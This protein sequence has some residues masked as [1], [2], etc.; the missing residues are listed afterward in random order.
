MNSASISL[1]VDP[2]HHSPSLPPFLRPIELTRKIPF[3]HLPSALIPDFSRVARDKNKSARAPSSAN[4]YY[5]CSR[6]GKRNPLRMCITVNWKQLKWN[7]INACAQVLAREWRTCKRTTLGTQICCTWYQFASIAYIN[8]HSCDMHGKFSSF[9]SSIP[10]TN[11]N[12]KSSTMLMSCV[13]VKTA[14]LCPA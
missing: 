6:M 1:T 9:D 11:S 12:A 10:F 14:N 5:G 4:Y 13:Q 3:T 8:A 7:K 2:I